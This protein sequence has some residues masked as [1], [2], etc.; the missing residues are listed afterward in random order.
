MGNFRSSSNRTVGTRR[1]IGSTAATGS[2]ST[3]GSIRGHELFLIHGACNFNTAAQK[4]LPMGYN[5]TESAAG[6][7]QNRFVAPCRGRWVKSYVRSTVAADTS[8]LK[9][10]KAT[11]TTANTNILLETV[12]VEMAAASTTYEFSS[13][14][15]SAGVPFAEGDVIAWRFDPETQ[16]D[17]TNFTHVLELYTR[18][19]IV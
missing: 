13:G 16:P 7:Y 2:S 5:D 18:A 1:H 15:G 6:T 10:Y 9:L 12:T 17:L 11:D 3:S 8:I 19:D 4:F 14:T